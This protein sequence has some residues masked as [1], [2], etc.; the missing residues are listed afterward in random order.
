MAR[1]TKADKAAREAAEA[2][3]AEAQAQAD[4]ETDAG[5]VATDD[6]ALEASVAAVDTDALLGDA[7]AKRQAELE[8]GFAGDKVDP[9]PNEAHSLESGP[10]AP[11]LNA[12]AEAELEDPDA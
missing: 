12:P 3:A 7:P 8:Q 9:L 10:D 6:E 5:K 2:T 11:V 4:V 1:E